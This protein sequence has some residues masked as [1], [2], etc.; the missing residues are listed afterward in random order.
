MKQRHVSTGLV[1]AAFCWD[2][3]LERFIKRKS[4]PVALNTKVAYVLSG[5][6]ENSHQDESNSVIL[7][8]V[9]K[10]QAEIIHSNDR[11]KD[12]FDKVWHEETIFKTDIH[13][14]DIL[15]EDFDYKRFIE[16]KILYWKY[17]FRLAIITICLIIKLIA[18]N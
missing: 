15:D 17:T 6:I 8:H 7:T 10:V 13:L 3:V 5:R 1:G 9:M 4:G 11:I 18:K 16:E 14:N 2:I 12:D